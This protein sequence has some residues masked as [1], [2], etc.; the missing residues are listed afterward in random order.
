MLGPYADH[1]TTGG[2]SGFVSPFRTTTVAGGM[3]KIHRNTV[4]SYRQRSVSRY[5]RL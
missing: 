3:K 1:V 5:S 4:V 2:G